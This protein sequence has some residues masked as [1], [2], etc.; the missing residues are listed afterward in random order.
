MAQVGDILRRARQERGIAIE[1]AEQITRIPR[2]YLVALEGEDYGALPAPVYARGFLRSYAS[3]LGLEPRDLLPLFPVGQP[4]EARL[5]P[6][7][8]VRDPRNRSQSTLLVL[9]AAGGLIL[10]IFA[11]FSFS[12]DGGTNSLIG[13]NEVAQDTSSVPLDGNA[14]LGNRAP[15]PDF[16]GLTVAEAIAFTKSQ[17]V[18]YITIGVEDEAPTGLIVGQGPAP[19]QSLKPG[20]TVALFVSR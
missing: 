17:S 14:P 7:P 2:K 9:G 20:D 13:G 19:G 5:Q 16:L 8:R 4:E 3:Y 12:Q 1:D 10:A 15:L 18:S 6:L 11:I